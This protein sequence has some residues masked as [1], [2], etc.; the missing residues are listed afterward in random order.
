MKTIKLTPRLAG[1]LMAAVIGEGIEAH[2]RIWRPSAENS[3]VLRAHVNDRLLRVVAG[4]RVQTG[5]RVRRRRYLIDGRSGFEGM[6]DGLICGLGHHPAACNA[7]LVA[8][9]CRWR[10]LHVMSMETRRAIAAAPRRSERAWPD[11][12]LRQTDPCQYLPDELHGVARLARLAFQLVMAIE[13]IARSVPEGYYF[14]V[15]GH[16]LRRVGL[17]SAVDELIARGL[18][19]R[20]VAARAGVSRSFVLRRRRKNSGR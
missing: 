9:M 18:S 11:I 20:N 5:F 19:D 1:L 10:D 16:E 8:L 6:R 12:P 7:A 2:R 13:S 17:M 4:K 15:R 3:A 14:P